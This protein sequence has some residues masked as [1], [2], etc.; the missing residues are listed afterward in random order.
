MLLGFTLAGQQV[1]PG[2]GL[3]LELEL[4]LELALEVLLWLEPVCSQ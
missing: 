1:T 3:K 2:L 4:E